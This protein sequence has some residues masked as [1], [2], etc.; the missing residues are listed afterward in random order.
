[1]SWLG[2]LRDRLVRFELEEAGTEHGAGGT[3]PILRKDF[4]KNSINKVT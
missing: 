1:M 3:I 2:K 4:R